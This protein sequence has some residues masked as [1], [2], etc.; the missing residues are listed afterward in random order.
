MIKKPVY[1]DNAAATPMDERVKL[2]MQP[3]FSVKFYN[4]SA[5]YLSARAVS[6]DIEIARTR[7]SYWLGTKSTNLV[8]TAGGTEANNLAINGVMRLYPK[9]NIVV[10]SIEHESILKPAQKFKNKIAPVDNLGLIDITKLENLIDDN[11]VLVS[12]MY[13][14]NEIGVIQPIYQISKILQKIRKDRKNSNNSL[15]MYLHTDACQASAYLDLHISRLGVDLMTLNSGK[16]YGPKQF[17]A[18][19]IDKH[20][21]LE[22]QILGG[23]QERGFRSGTENPAN[24]VGFAEALDLVQSNRVTESKKMTDLQTYFIAGLT[25]NIPNLYVNGSLKKRLPNNVHITIPGQDNELILM[26]LDE[27]GIH[28]A[29][30]SAC[31]ATN[32]EISTTLL[33]LGMSEVNARSSLRFTMGKYTT[34]SDIDYVISSISKI[35][36]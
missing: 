16:I 17:G 32:Q 9:A 34:K 4:P 23:G 21:N 20:V 29:S 13:A 8:F 35:L 2:A 31:N 24:I 33:A 7:I 3:Y 5:Q 28:C 10:G 11:T 6:K 18:L 12:I 27:L 15:P 25:K 36:E 30:G 14:N 19:F 22:P 26:K 1:L